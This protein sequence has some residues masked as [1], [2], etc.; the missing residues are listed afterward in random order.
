MILEISTTH[1]PATDL[2]YLLH[3]NP[4]RVHCAEMS[5][6]T[7]TVFYPEATE[8]RCT[9]TLMM[10]VD[11]VGL[12]RGSGVMEQYVNDRPYVASSFLCTAIN[13][14]FRTAMTGKCKDRP[15]LA[16]TAIPL[17]AR[18]PVISCRGGEVFLSLLFEPLGY[19][20]RA[21][22]LPLDPQFPEWGESRYF[23][24]T[25]RATARLADLL[26]HLYV[27]IPVL[28]DDK[29]YYIDEA[30]VEKLMRRGEG[31]LASHPHKPEIVARYLRRKSLTR[32]ALERLEQ[33]VEE[34]DEAE[35][36]HDQ[37]ELEK[38]EKPI[39]LHEVRLNEVAKVI[40]DSGATF[41]GDLGCGEGR[42][43]RKLRK[44]PKIKR[45]VGMDV[46]VSVLEYCHR[47]LHLTDV[48]KREEG[49]I[50]LMHGSLTYRD[51]R[52]EG[53]DA[54][55][56]VEVIEHL[57][58]SRLRSLERVVFEFARPRMV[59]VTTPNS[60]YN[61]L[62]GLGPGVM[63]H[64]DHRFEWT[65]AEFSAWAKGVAE[66]FGYSVETQPLGPVDEAHGAPS[67]MAV[68]KR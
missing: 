35:A 58:Q 26:T 22:R 14:V 62:Y 53:F 63:R 39:S 36:A 48:T 3:K 66:R 17:E 46:A 44:E 30:E 5:F 54:A 31:W 29:H 60:G 7:T 1:T 27:L 51:S 4:A 15:E 11:P 59:V 28:D 20:V 45:I 65:R 12:V 32:D 68:F 52:L 16:E 64:K 56:L 42:L 61:E 57:D 18:L 55:A 24:V 43:I 50:T 67:Q 8:V 6:G 23:D 13:Q 25:L 21:T 9:A 40:V 2:G 19:E 49:R 34:V 38:F 37:E 33:D 41:V 47:N 10:E